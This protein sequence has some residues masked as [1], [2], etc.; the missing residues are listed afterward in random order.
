MTPQN[1]DMTAGVSESFLMIG[2]LGG[3]LVAAQIGSSNIQRLIE[4]TAACYSVEP[5]SRAGQ[6]ERER[7]RESRVE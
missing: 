4:K 3:L 1:Q 6:Q 5:N 7:E 2:F